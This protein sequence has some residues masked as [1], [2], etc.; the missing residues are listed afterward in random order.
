MISLS[1]WE[2]LPSVIQR[3]ERLARSKQPPS[4]TLVALGG[5]LLISL[6]VPSLARVSGGSDLHWGGGAGRGGRR[7]WFG[8]AG[9]ARGAAHHASGGR[10]HQLS[11]VLRLAF[12]AGGVAEQAGRGVLLFG[13]RRGGRWC[14]PVVCGRGRDRCGWVR[15]V[16]RARLWS[17]SGGKWSRGSRVLGGSVRFTF[18][19]GGLVVRWG[20]GMQA[21]WMLGSLG[22]LVGAPLGRASLFVASTE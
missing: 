10:G 3:S 20:F 12:V 7:V 13:G 16:G 8:V 6:V 21:I 11:S 19:A 14:W 17:V 1:S 5:Q 2:S 15:R 18:P 4:L 22:S 9:G